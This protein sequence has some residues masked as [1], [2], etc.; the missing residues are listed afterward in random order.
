MQSYS[1]LFSS[2][3]TNI[4]KSLAAIQKQEW[5]DVL[6]F[7]AHILSKYILCV[8]TYLFGSNVHLL[9]MQILW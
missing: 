9:L 7:G 6:K 1:H 3:N 2:I 5:K 8:L 4:S